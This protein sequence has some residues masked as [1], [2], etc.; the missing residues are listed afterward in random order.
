[1]S[2]APQTAL[3]EAMIARADADGLPA[4]HPL[5]VTAAALDDAAADRSSEPPEV[6]ARMFVGAWA[7]AR[8][9]WCNYTGAPLI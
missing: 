1:M 6:R 7:R 2:A 4:D 3:G 5:R 8:R 9:A